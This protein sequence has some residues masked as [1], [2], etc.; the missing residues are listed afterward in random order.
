M[1]KDDDLD[2]RARTA[3]ASGFW[4]T[5]RRCARSDAGRGVRSAYLFKPADRDPRALGHEHR[6]AAAA[7]R[8]G[9]AESA[10][11]RDHRLLSG[12]GGVGPGDA[13][14]PRRRAAKL[15]RRY[16]S[17]GPRGARPIRCS[18]MPK[19]WVRPPQRCRAAPGMHRF[20][21]DMHYPPL[22]GG[23]GAELSDA[24]IVHD[25]PPAPS[26]WVLP[27]QYT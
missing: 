13:R 27:G 25:T 14:D 19:Y 16:S 4:T 21:W 7:R 1:V 5:S 22:P 6:H 12:R 2:R 17:D 9:R 10:G 20:L 26:V 24:A 8:A 3:A 18:P 15:V 11:R 23:G